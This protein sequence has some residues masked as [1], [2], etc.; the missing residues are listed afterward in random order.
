MLV[1]DGILTDSDRNGVVEMRPLVKPALRR[2]W[3]DRSSVQF[4]VDPAHAVVLESVDGAAAGFLDL[5][6][7]TRSLAA[8][9]RDAEALG[10]SRAQAARLL[11]LL[12]AGGVLDDAA[13]YAAPPGAGPRSA[14]PGDAGPQGAAQ[15]SVGPRADELP[16]AGPPGAGSRSHRPPR[17]APPGRLRPDLAALSLVHPAPGAAPARLAGRRAARV[18]VM[19]AGRI[20]SAVAAL[21]AAAGVGRVEVRDAGRVE[22]A[23]TGPCGFPAER[24]GERRE[25]AASALVRRAAPDPRAASVGR[26]GPA[27]APEP[28][29]ALVVLA[30]RDGLAAFAP[31]A[32]ELA[33]L[34]A[35]GIP[36]LFTGVLEGTGLVGPLVVPG[37][38]SCARCLALRLADADPAWPRVLAQARSR[39]P[40]GVPP[41]DVAHGT[42]VA[43]LAASH[44]LAF[45]DGGRPPSVDGRVELGLAGLRTA[46]RPLPGDPRCDCGAARALGDA[47]RRARWTMTG[48]TDRKEGAHV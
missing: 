18:R 8:L 28:P 46:V 5:L 4:G 16:G 32:A 9:A 21:L 14:G 3:R 13:A 34:L 25:A 48:V 23:D 42:A 39:P 44:A 27:A 2:T 35:A 7:G 30:P 19:G 10:V 45:L 41:C 11:A 24:C 1:G 26:R 37:S 38:S 20:G 29:L 31:D 43:A 15:P 12:S 33:E 36:H 40:R 6:D 17:G 22:A 47:V